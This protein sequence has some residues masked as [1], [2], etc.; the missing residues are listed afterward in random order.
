MG[1]RTASQPRVLAAL[2]ATATVVALSLSIGPGSTLGSNGPEAVT[3]KKRFCKTHPRAKRC[4]RLRITVSWDDNA[5]IDLYVWDAALHR[6]SPFTRFAIPRAFHGGDSGVLPEKF[7]DRRRTPKRPFAFGICLRQ[8]PSFDPTV[9][10]VTYH[11]PDGSTFVDTDELF[12]AGQSIL[13]LS[14]G[15]PDPDPSNGGVWCPP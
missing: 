9:F 7:F 8:E 4:R 10:T 14:D 12:D 2:I 11:R 6:A 5:N 1:R 3:A 13:Y 15:V